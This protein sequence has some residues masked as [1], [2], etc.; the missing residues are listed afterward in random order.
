M[1]KHFFALALALSVLPISAVAQ[2][3][4]TA[5]AGTA[6]QSQ[7]QQM[8]QFFDQFKQ[9][10]GQLHQ[11]LRSQILSDLT[12]VHRRA[13]AA[14]IGD[15]AVS[16]NPDAQ[17]TAK[18]IDSIL[19]PGERSRIISAHEQYRNQAEQMHQQIMSQLKSQFPTCPNVIITT[20]TTKCRI[21]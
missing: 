5:P 12:P 21:R 2:T 6:G 3:A 20:K 7:H 1:N 9:Q 15:L 16:A 13:I 17:A 4:T 10:E 14:E 18:R 8:R 19:S 11:Q